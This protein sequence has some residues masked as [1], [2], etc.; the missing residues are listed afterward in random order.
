M[1]KVK[2]RG[3]RYLLGF[4]EPD[5]GDQANMPVEQAL[6]LWPRLMGTGLILGSPSVATGGELP[7]GWLDRFMKGAKKRKLRVDFITL[8]WYGADFRAKPAANAPLRFTQFTDRVYANTAATCVIHDETLGR[9]ITIEKQN[10]N[11][12]VVFNPW[13]ELPDLG[14]DEWREFACVETVN[15]GPNKVTLAPR[16]THV[17]QAHVTLAKT[18][19]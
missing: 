3:H 1:A 19:K 10:S 5:L 2:G 8:H 15:A 11:T 4:N 18:K 12:T 14:P 7:G 17:M 9:T 6:D 16:S 13:R